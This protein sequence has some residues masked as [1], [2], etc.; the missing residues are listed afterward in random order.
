MKFPEIYE[1]KKAHRIHED[2]TLLFIMKQ[3]RGHMTEA[4]VTLD[5]LIDHLEQDQSSSNGSP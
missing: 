1:H 4:A 2:Q 3:L 5:K